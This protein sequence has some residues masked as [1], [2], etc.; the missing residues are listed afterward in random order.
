VRFKLARDTVVIQNT[1]PW[2]RIV[3]KV[4]HKQIPIL[5]SLGDEAVG[6]ARVTAL[7]QARWRQE[8]FFKYARAHLGLDVLTS[9]ASET[10]DDHEVSNPKFKAAQATVKQLRARASKLQAALGKVMLREATMAT[11]DD[12]QT[13]ASAKPKRHSAKA[14]TTQADLL[15]TLRAAESELEQ[16]QATLKALPQRVLVSSLG[17]LPQVP[18]LEAKVLTDTVKLAAYNA[19]A[20]LAERLAHH[21]A[22]TD[23]RFDLLRSFA[24]LPGS[25]TR[26][27]DGSLLVCLEPPSIP[28]CSRALDGLCQELNLINPTFPGTTIPLRYE[29][30]MH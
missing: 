10:T 11:A 6:P 1:G 18:Q 24:E 5:T 26:Q 16:A 22:S 29:V 28:L 8:N 13:P 23:D 17:P 4:K 2:R 25:M 15:A 21:Y 9:Y 7:I 14:A 27:A 20:W 30:A 19:Q 3:L 12:D